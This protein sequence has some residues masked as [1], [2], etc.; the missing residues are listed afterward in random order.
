M[1]NLS[2]DKK[3]YLSHLFLLLHLPLRH[4]LLFTCM[5]CIWLC[6][7]TQRQRPIVYLYFSH[8][9]VFWI[10]TLWHTGTTCSKCKFRKIKVCLDIKSARILGHD[11]NR[12]LEHYTANALQHITLKG[13]YTQ[14]VYSYWHFSANIYLNQHPVRWFLMCIKMK[15]TRKGPWT[16]TKM[17][18]AATDTTYWI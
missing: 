13:K 11:F 9:S 17:V 4:F 18:S 12:A 8:F 5:S 3:E 2:Y 1:R 6:H 16:L 14:L 7:Y 15:N 10:F